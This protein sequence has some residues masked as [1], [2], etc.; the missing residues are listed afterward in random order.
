MAAFICYKQLC[1]LPFNDKSYMSNVLYLTPMR[2]PTYKYIAGKGRR[3]KCAW[4]CIVFP[5]CFK[6]RAN[7]SSHLG[8][9]RACFYQPLP[10][11]PRHC[12][13]EGAMR[14]VKSH[15]ILLEWIRGQLLFSSAATLLQVS[16]CKLQIKK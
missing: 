15:T 5:L 2:P 3:K 11:G 4:A 12:E 1:L 10:A 8:V 13:M 16:S 6:I 9:R 7:I 14:K